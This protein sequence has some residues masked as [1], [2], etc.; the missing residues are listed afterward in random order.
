MSQKLKLLRY[1][2]FNYLIT[3]LILPSHIGSGSPLIS[4]AQHVGFLMKTTFEL[5]TQDHHFW[6]QDKLSIIPKA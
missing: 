3:I 1:N 4:G 5:Q 2:E 6:Y